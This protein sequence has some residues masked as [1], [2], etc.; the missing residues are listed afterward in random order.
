MNNVQLEAGEERKEEKGK[1]KFSL[2]KF[3]ESHK[4][5][6]LVLE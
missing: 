1:K 3:F 2:E 5:R 6:F 4:P